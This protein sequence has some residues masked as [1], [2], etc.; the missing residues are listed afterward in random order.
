M[1]FHFVLSAQ[2]AV[3]I[4]WPC[5]R[6]NWAWRNVWTTCGI[7]TVI[8]VTQAA[9]TLPATT[10]GGIFVN[11]AA[12]SSSAPLQTSVPNSQ[13][14]TVTGNF[15][16]ASGNAPWLCTTGGGGFG[17][18]PTA[19]TPIYGG[20]MQRNRCRRMLD[21]YGNLVSLCATPKLVPRYT[22]NLVNPGASDYAPSSAQT[23]HATNAAALAIMAQEC[24]TPGPFMPSVTTTCPG[25]MGWFTVF[26][27]SCAGGIGAAPGVAPTMPSAATQ[28]SAL[29]FPD[30]LSPGTAGWTLT[31]PL[32]LC[33]AGNGVAGTVS[34]T[35]WNVAGTAFHGTKCRRAIDQFVRTSTKCSATGSPY[36]GSDPL[37]GLA[38]QLRTIAPGCN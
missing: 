2:A 15:N 4:G 33:G 30:Y 20:T 12:P 38:A 29:F 11:Q 37:L 5:Q 25:L 9:L 32:N 8:P 18:V 23:P 17:V 1:L 3:L 14:S 21:V 7:N 6:L 28:P 27:N 10:P 19:N 22:P 31:S 16:P 35:Q 24:I 34:A 36:G 13:M 26:W